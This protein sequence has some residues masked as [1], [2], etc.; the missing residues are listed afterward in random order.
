MLLVSMQVCAHVHAGVCM[1][2]CVVIVS[3][4]GCIPLIMLVDV[5]QCCFYASLLKLGE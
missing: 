5:Y 4:D 1:C 3:V 2:M